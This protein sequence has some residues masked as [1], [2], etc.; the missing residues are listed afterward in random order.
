V[1]LV[2]VDVVDDLHFRRIGVEG[3]VLN[4]LRALPGARDADRGAQRA[5]VDQLDGIGL[6]SIGV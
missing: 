2:P 6:A 4:E 1:G 5:F 3:D